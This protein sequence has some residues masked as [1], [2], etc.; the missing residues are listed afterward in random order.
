MK[1]TFLFTLCAT[2]FLLTACSRHNGTSAPI[3]QQLVLPEDEKAAP[4]ALE[5]EVAS[6]PGSEASD[7]TA[8]LPISQKIIKEGILR[9]ETNDFENAK[10]RITDT[11]KKYGG[12]LASEK[13]ENTRLRW[14]NQMVVKIPSAAFEQCMESLTGGS[15]RVDEKSSTSTD[16]TDAYIDLDARMKARLAVEQRYVQILQQARNVK[17]ILEVE[18]QL[19]SIREEIESAKGRLQ[20]M[21]HHVAYSTINL[22]YYQQFANTDPQSPGFFQRSW[23]AFAD[24]W[25]GLLSFAIGILSGWPLMVGMV[26]LFIFIK[27][28]IRRRKLRKAPTNVNP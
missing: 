13:E 23:F 28:V 17:E 15:S 1:H 11:V 12:Y 16:V 25:N 7:N 2:A 22:E 26:F 27:R 6:D 10:K 3:A 24:G 20:Y 18:A 5:K 8:A 19:K 9:F 14:Q 21:D 4:A